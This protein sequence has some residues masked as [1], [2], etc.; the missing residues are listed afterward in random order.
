MN[1]ARRI[2]LAAT[3]C[4]ALA[5]MGP[6][7]QAGDEGLAGAAQISVT[8]TGSELSFSGEVY[9]STANEVTGLHTIAVDGS[10]AVLILWNETTTDGLTLPFYAVS[11]DGQQIARV[12]QTSYTLGLRHAA[13][14]P[15]GAAPTARAGLTM[16]ADGN[17]YIVQFATQPLEE[18]RT[19]IRNMGGKVYQ[20]VANHA[21]FVVMTPDVL[22]QVAGLP[23]VRAITP[24]HPAYK[25]EEEILTQI[26][27]GQQVA[28]RRYSIMLHER[29]IA[30]QD[31]VSAFIKQ[32][33]GKVFGS[34]PKGF[35]IEANLT[36]DQVVQ[37]AGL[38]DVMFIDRKNP[39]EIDMDLV[40]ELGG[41]NYLET[42]AGFTGQG[43][44]AEVADTEL[45]VNHQ[46]WGDPP[47]IHR[48]GSD[49]AHGTSVYGILFAQGVVPQARG[50]IPDA[51][52]IFACST[53][54]LIGGGTTRYDHTAELVDPGDIYRT[55]FQT[56]STGDSRT[57]EY[58]T[59]S[60]E[61]D[62]MLF[63]YDIVL[64]QS[65]SNAGS[66][67]SRPQAWAK[68]IISGGAVNHY[69]TLTRD[70]D[71]WCNT[72][73]IGPA[74]DGRIK[75]DLCFFYD[76]T[77]TA[78]SGGGYTEFG[79]TS[80]ATP[81]IAG[82]VGLFFQ[83]WSEG[84]FGNEVDPGADV[85]DNRCHMTTAKAALINTANPYDFSGSSADLTR[86]HQ[87]WGNPSVA[88]LWDLRDK[89]SFIDET[90]VLGNMESV[91]YVAYVEEGT[92]ELRV[93][94]VYADPMGV[95]TA[96]QQRI[97]DLSLRVISPTGDIYWGNNGLLA[98]NWSTIGGSADDADTVENVFVQSPQSG[99]W[100]VTVFADEV[101]QDSHVETP[102]V[103][104]DFALVLSGGF[105]ATCTPDGHI[106][107]DSSDYLCEDVVNVRVVDCDLNTDP[108]AVETVQITVSSDTE[109][110]GE[111]ITL[112]ETA[113][114][115]ADF[116]G[117][118]SISTAD[119]AGVL[120]VTEGDLITATYIDADDGQGGT[121]VVV[122]DTALVD[123]T[124]PQIFNVVVADVEPRSAL[125]T[126]ETDEDTVG[127]VRFGDACG[128]LTEVASQ[129]GY[130]TTHEVVISGLTD[131]T[132]YFFAVDAADVAGNPATDDNGG[133]CY[134][135]T[136]PDIP[137]FFTEMFGSNDLDGLKLL[138]SPNSTIDFYAGCVEEITELPT[139]PAGGTTISLSDDD[140]EQITL[141]DGA[142]V[143]LYGVSY[144]SFYVSSNGYLTFGASDTDY[145]ETLEEHFAIPRVAALYDDLNP[146]S[147]GTVSWKQLE[148]RVAVT[149]LNVPEYNETTTNTFQIELFFNG[150]LHISYLDLAAT[151]GLA[152]LSEGEGLDPDYYA[153]DL[154][155]MG[156]CGP[157]PPV[158]SGDSVSTTA[159][160][161]VT[162]MLTATDDGLP[163]PA[164]LV[165][166]ITTLPTSGTLTDPQAGAIDT[167]P[168]EL[169]NGGNEVTYTPGLWFYGTDAFNFKANDGG[170]AP[171]GGD[172]NEAV[173]S[174]DVTLPAADLIYS[175]PLDS[176]P[177]WSTEGQWAY[178]TPMGWGSHNADPDA[179]Y[180]GGSVYGYNLLGDYANNLAA[181]YY[182]TT[183]AIDCSGLIS[184]ELRF[185]RWLGVERAP[186]DNATIEVSN[187]GADWTTLWSNPAGGSISDSAWSQIVFDISAEAD[188]EPTVY[189]R[190]SMGS[191][192]SGTSY[193]GWNIDDVEIYGID[194][195]PQIVGDLD[196]DCDVDLADLQILLS[197]YG[198]TGAGYAGDLDGDNDVDLA[199]L[200][201]LLAS[202]GQ[203]CP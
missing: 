139:D 13:F 122:T 2:L 140:A 149:Y 68:N 104:A 31:R 16:P 147:G 115:T 184:T 129:T 114:E 116:R 159:N 92:P 89:I 166:I 174:I 94:L 170:V 97:N 22:E 164:T 63:I 107:V 200:Q 25:L 69:N 43:V 142:E 27:T 59:I 60:A 125:I 54:G 81:S 133:N 46:E 99:V 136:T 183:T 1:L 36:L 172:S 71:C 135:F 67:D 128:N 119:A 34:T 52:G 150:D 180:T 7:A 151:D 161:P 162:V 137:N 163:E 91:E 187:N 148:D 80:G 37:I 118:I 3:L 10:Q 42:V 178:G 9:R 201:T 102:E 188:G 50:L 48:A 202:Y 15:L 5:A 96:A 79:G 181:P 11:K 198:Q 103:D 176:D 95:P 189:V 138:F 123:C 152:G 158:A 109:S 98:G 112:T 65:Q 120:W 61:M 108:N 153:T 197:N 155:G 160:T 35:R 195:T 177:G 83:M 30:A 130:G 23:Y 143:S 101:N 20:F 110:A 56:N 173:I 169:A 78:T 182:L 87:G 86:V 154:S 62:D 156:A 32:I 131:E 84:V 157:K 203:S 45:D 88:N 40:R 17:L 58:T 141:S 117:S 41:A 124:P 185:W 55:V 70:D 19:A 82:H 190:W 49:T 12:T 76:D 113:G 6:I 38:D 126:F 194:T 74:S 18:F 53:N 28:M 14:D 64:T 66:R 24:V 145:D 77:Y 167:V 72:G 75:P 127:S 186:Y 193:P 51:V 57:T 179:G 165:Y 175:Y 111:T 106:T 8:D 105:L 199:D 146:S 4:C 171:E 100:S 26:E 90:E 192:D 191:T 29:G 121:N 134:Y 196:G 144:G 73:S 47:I 33:G 39:T 85:F 21:H 44:R 168:Y 93:T 132:T